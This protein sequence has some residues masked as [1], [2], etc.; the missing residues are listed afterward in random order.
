M[1]TKDPKHEEEVKPRTLFLETTDG[2]FRIT[3]PA[4]ARVTFGPT[5]PYEK[6]G[7]SYEPGGPRGYS[8]R[9]YQNSKN[10]SLMAV[11]GGVRSFRD[12]SIPHAKLI[13]REAGTTVWKSDEEGFKVEN[14]VKKSEHWVGGLKQLED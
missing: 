2:E 10:D 14:E 4:G 13:V 9:V 1:P 8:L 5:V 6:K 7:N 12:T 3:I 11:F